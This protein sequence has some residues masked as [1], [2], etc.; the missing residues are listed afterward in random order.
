MIAISESSRD[1]GPLRNE[2]NE[3]N[4]NPQSHH[5]GF[6]FLSLAFSY[7]KQ[8]CY[9]SREPLTSLFI[10]DTN[11]KRKVT[12]EVLTAASMKIAVFWVVAPCSLV[13]VYRRFTGACCIHHQ[14]DHKT[15]RRNNPEDSDLNTT[16]QF[17]VNT[18][19]A[20]IYIYI[21]HMTNL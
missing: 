14:G 21:S 10:G 16:K 6:N 12:L 9:I 5:F 15:T 4:H 13:E 8:R 3:P 1:E 7:I 20:Y 17:T 18:T 2:T 11:S 19:E